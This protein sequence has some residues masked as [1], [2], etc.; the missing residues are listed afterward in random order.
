M[1]HNG[2]DLLASIAAERGVIWSTSTDVCPESPQV[3]SRASLL[4][5][6]QL[7]RFRILS[8]HTNLRLRLPRLQWGDVALEGGT[9]NVERA[10]EEGGTANQ[11]A[12][13]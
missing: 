6:V 10:V 2:M 11:A 7:P 5:A 13:D 3:M 9:L 1:G 12:K 8:C 4:E